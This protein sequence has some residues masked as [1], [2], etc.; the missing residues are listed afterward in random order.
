MRL[1]VC[2]PMRIEA[3]ALRAGLPAGALR[4]TGPGPRRSARRAA[5]LATEHFEALAVAGLGGGLD[6]AAR[7]GRIVV[8][9]E[10]RGARGTFP[11]PLAGALVD[12]LSRRGLPV[13]CG[14]VLT[15]D[16]LVRGRERAELARTGALAVDTESAELAAAAAGRP[17]AVARVLLDT[18]RD[19]LLLAPGHL[20]RALRLLRQLSPSLDRWSR[21]VPRVGEDVPTAAP[22]EGSP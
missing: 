15:T 3:R 17:L 18:P 12:E 9:S 20:R 19:P 11:C 6:P 21:S 10:V 5:Q 14:P 22:G 2:A 7:S 16:H 4:R 1:L 13:T 8:A